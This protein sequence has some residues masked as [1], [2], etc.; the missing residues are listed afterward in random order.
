MDGPVP[1]VERAPDPPAA[2][3]MLSLVYRITDRGVRL[4]SRLAQFDDAP[5]LSLAG[6]EAYAPE[7]PWVMGPDG[8][9]ARL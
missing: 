2:V 1:A 4:R 9:L 5:R 8:R 3:P 6:V 7:A